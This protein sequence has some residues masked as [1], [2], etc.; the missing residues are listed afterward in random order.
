MKVR[1]REYV[2]MSEYEAN[3]LGI[4]RELAAVE[5]VLAEEVDRLAFFEWAWWKGCNQR[6]IS[7]LSDNLLQS[8]T[9]M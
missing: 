7:L 9:R 2:E 1:I 5:A 3:R 4:A 8:L 6:E